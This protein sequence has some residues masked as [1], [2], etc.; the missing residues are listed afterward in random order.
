MCGYKFFKNS[1]KKLA[2]N[3]LP[4]FFPKFCL[5]CGVEGEFVCKKCAKKIKIEELCCPACNKVNFAGR[6]CKKHRKQVKFDGLLFV[7][8]FLGINKK[9]IHNFKYEG[10]KELSSLMAK[11]MAQ[12][13]AQNFRAEEKLVLVPVPLFFAKRLSR[14]FNQSEILAQKLSQ[15]LDLPI[16]N[17][18][19]RIKATK[20]QT[21]FTKEKR[22][23]NVKDAFCLSSLGQ[24]ENLKNKTVVL[25]DDVYTTGAT[26]NE[27]AKVLKK[28]S[29]SRRAKEIWALTFCKD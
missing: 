28:K 14:G 23:E 11:V 17:L 29:A 1:F 3:I 26:L 19:L 13:L 20:S 6:F 24:K 16:A 4:L 27:A 15:I 18:L 9:I 25:V 8:R 5:G 21:H 12:V 2:N 10:I 22:L 7:G